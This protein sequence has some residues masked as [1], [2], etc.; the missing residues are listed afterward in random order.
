MCGD[1]VRVICSSNE[2]DTQGVVI[3]FSILNT[4]SEVCGCATK[5]DP[6]RPD[7]LIS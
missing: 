3:S 7:Q 6:M 5:K 4:M 2:F 1:F